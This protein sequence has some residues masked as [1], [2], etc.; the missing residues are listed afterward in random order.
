MST[1]RI[2]ISCHNTAVALGLKYLFREFFNLEA[3]IISESYSLDET[4]DSNQNALYFVDACTFTSNHDF[5]ITRRSRIIVISHGEIAYS[6]IPYIN[7]HTD[8]SSIID[9]LHNIITLHTNHCEVSLN[10]LSQREIEVLRLVAMGYINKE[11]ADLLE[12][13]INTVLSHRKNI[14]AKLGIR[15]VSGLGFY[16]IMHGYISDS[17]IRR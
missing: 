2:I 12:I 13:S 14:T 9:K 4:V 16:A 1:L 5:L 11:I 10:E 7:T 3:V 6:D 17:D 8:E 15:S